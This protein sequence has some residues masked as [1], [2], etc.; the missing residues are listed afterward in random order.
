MTPLEKAV[1]A[2]M[3]RLNHPITSEDPPYPAS[4]M[5]IVRAVIA[6]VKGFES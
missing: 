4:L 1:L 3:V 5:P 2:D 6:T